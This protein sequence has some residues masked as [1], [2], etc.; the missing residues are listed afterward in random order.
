M[1][2][3][4]PIARIAV[5]G[6]LALSANACSWAQ[7]KY[8]PDHTGYNPVES[9]I[10]VDNVSRLDAVWRAP[11]YQV[12]GSSP[13][14]V[15]GTVY[16]G[17]ELQ[18]NRPV[19][20]AFDAAGKRGCTT[21]SVSTCSPLW[22]GTLD[23]FPFASPAVVGKFAYV[24]SNNPGRLYAFDASGAT[25]CSG[26]PKICTPL[27]TAGQTYDP[28]QGQWVGDNLYSS[29]VVANGVVYV[30]GGD[31]G[32]FAYDA[33]GRQKCSGTTRVC[34]PLWTTA[35]TSTFTPA[36]PTVANGVVYEGLAN[37]AIG[38]YDATGVQ[39][40]GGAPKT[41]TPL[42]I[43]HG[44]GTNLISS[45]AVVKGVLYVGGNMLHAF[46]VAGTTNC[47]GTPLTCNPLWTA[48]TGAYIAA[49]P[50][51]ANGVVYVGSQNSKFYAFDAKG[52]T[53]CSGAPKTCAPLWSAVTGSGLFVDG[54]AAIANGLVYVGAEDGT[55]LAFDAAGHTRCNATTRVCLPLWSVA[56]GRSFMTSGAAVVDGTVYWTGADSAL[57]AYKLQP[58]PG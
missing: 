15:N 26:S 8:G 57:R 6:V 4:F 2:P 46:D 42:R 53:G 17:G 25:G 51:V 33:A 21:P 55:L 48:N 14:V 28:V 24:V 30:S 54:P 31:G 13:A 20:A 27:W 3:R 50:S 37:G 19:I 58:G 18:A 5:L 32:L 47:S 36:E 56:N 22:R 49:S 7:Y 10:S 12:E 29:P 23:G 44:Q 52:V 9:T 43:L 38:A 39:K 16:L 35:L 34:T 11:M 40:C 1:R 45:P 41:C